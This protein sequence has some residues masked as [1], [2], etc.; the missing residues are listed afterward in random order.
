MKNLHQNFIMRH[1]NGPLKEPE[2]LYH[3][4]HKKVVYLY[5][6]KQDINLLSLE[7][8]PLRSCEHCLISVPLSIVSLLVS[9]AEYVFRPFYLS[10]NTDQ[11][12]HGPCF[13][14]SSIF[15]G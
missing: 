12:S 9:I 7:T 3:C 13:S 5:S 8:V 11:Y 10:A 14:F 6:S 2:N 4:T 1:K 15:G